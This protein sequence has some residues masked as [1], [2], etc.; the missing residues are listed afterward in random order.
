M[1]LAVLADI[2]GNLPAL[3]EVLG[4]IK[5]WQPDR[6][7][8][9]GDVVNRGPRPSECL[10][11]IQEK[12]QQSGWLVVRG[13]HEDY[14]LHHLR[15]EWPKSGPEFEIYRGSHWTLKQLDGQV[16]ALEAM[17]FQISLPAPDGREVRVVHASMRGNQ[18]G[19]YEDTGD[20]L[21][22]KQISP[23]PAVF[24]VGHTHRPL[25]RVIDSTLVVNAGSVGMPFD[26]DSRSGYAQLTWRSGR[27]H[28][29]IIRLEYDREQMERDFFESGFSP[30]AGPLTELMLIEFRL[31]RPFLHLWMRDYGQQVLSGAINIETAVANFIAGLD[32]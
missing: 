21:L 8:V 25:V 18:D 26:G 5:R 11:I 29:Q 14:V 1:K 16:G 2:H 9:A 7:V 17:P 12:Q 27:W 30:D 19:I 24:C 20:G 23:P 15:P 4:H 10:R 6:V 3:H 31:A 32:L 22:R 28:A 13:N